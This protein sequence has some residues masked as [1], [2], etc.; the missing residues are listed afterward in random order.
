MKSFI[1]LL[2]FYN[3]LFL[4]FG[5]FFGRVYIVSNV[6]PTSTKGFWILQS[7]IFG[8]ISVAEKLFFV[9]NTKTWLEN[10]KNN[11]FKSINQDT[12]LLI[13]K[14]LAHFDKNNNNEDTKLKES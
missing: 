3:K 12:S 14:Q 8:I 9:Y 5:V 6:L 1:F 13:M 2:T 10:S 7:S 4:L 11:S